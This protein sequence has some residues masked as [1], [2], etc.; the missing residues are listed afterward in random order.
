MSNSHQT[1]QP[2]SNTKTLTPLQSYAL[3][4][5]PPSDFSAAL[6]TC[7]S[8][9]IEPTSAEWKKSYA[10]LTV[11]AVYLAIVDA[12]T[13]QEIRTSG[14]SVEEQQP[15]WDLVDSQ[16]HSGSGGVHSFPNSTFQNITEQW[17]TRC[18][19]LLDSITGTSLHEYV[20]RIL[21]LGL[22]DM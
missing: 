14:V 11:L 6:E 17:F 18:L 1:L 20:S 12:Y 8:P 16:Q 4:L 5:P 3:G 15:I 22:A 21:F 19:S 7:T 10:V 2:P 13:C 9:L